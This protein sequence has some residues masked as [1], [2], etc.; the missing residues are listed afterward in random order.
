MTLHDK[1]ARG[2]APR[3][4]LVR[5]NTKLGRV[6]RR[7]GRRETI[8]HF[9]LPA[10]RTCPGASSAC[11]R[12]C[13]ALTSNFRLE[14]VRLNLAANLDAVVSSPLSWI[15]RLSFELEYMRATVC[16]IHVSGDFFEDWY[17]HAWQ[18][19]VRRHPGVRF[20]TYTRSWR[21]PSLVPALLALAKEPNMQMWFSCDKDTG[22]PPALA[23]PEGSMAAIKVCWLLTQHDEKPPRCDLIFRSHE[24]RRQ[25][26]KKIALT[27]VCPQEQS[28]DGLGKTSC[29]DCGICLPEGS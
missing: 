19:I 4:F 9:S 25:P 29:L 12:V 24:L 10:E 1:A 6:S 7:T 11:L 20:Y 3:T 23:F 22:L 26:R 27:V 13:Y 14:S 15:E 28:A 2:K 5:G 8:V 21:M 18:V 17:T 16:R